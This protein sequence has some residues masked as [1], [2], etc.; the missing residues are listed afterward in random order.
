M[1]VTAGM[2]LRNAVVST[3]GK[4]LAYSRGRR[5]VNLW[6]IPILRDRRATWSDATPLT[7]DQA[8]VGYVASVHDGQHI[9]FSSDRQGNQDIWVMPKAGG[10]MRQLTADPDTDIGP[11]GSPNG[12]KV[13]FYSN[14]SG[15]RDVWIVPIE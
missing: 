2:G 9:L 12:K 1:Q 4:K 15:N 5:K 10:E 14:R 11:V 7:F 13:A 6:K 3:D 8:F